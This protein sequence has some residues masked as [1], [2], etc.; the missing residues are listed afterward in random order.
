M[1]LQVDY[2][3]IVA[4]LHSLEVWLG[5]AQLGWGGQRSWGAQSA[6]GL[7]VSWTSNENASFTFI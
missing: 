5:K 7:V 2:V 6:G 1:L 4:M 3:V